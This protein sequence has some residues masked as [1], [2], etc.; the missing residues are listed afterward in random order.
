MGHH[1]TCDSTSP[2]TGEPIGTNQGLQPLFFGGCQLVGGALKLTFLPP[3]KVWRR[4]IQ[5]VGL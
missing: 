2:L 3:E 1:G 5:Q 4:A